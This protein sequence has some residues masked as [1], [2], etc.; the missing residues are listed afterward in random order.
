MPF[1]NIL[2]AP[3]KG[4]GF[5]VTLLLSREYGPHPNSFFARTLNKYD[6]PISKFSTWS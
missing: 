4:M 3:G 5:V 2:G 1:F 6:P